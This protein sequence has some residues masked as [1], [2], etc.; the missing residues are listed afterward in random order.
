MSRQKLA[1][2]P[3]LVSPLGLGLAKV[4]V[5]KIVGILLAALTGAALGTGPFSLTAGTFLI[6]GILNAVF[7]TPGFNAVGIIIGF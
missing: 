2:V 7:G 1:A 4:M 3:L 6:L 5:A